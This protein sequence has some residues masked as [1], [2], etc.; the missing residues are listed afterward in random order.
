METNTLLSQTL[1]KMHNRKYSTIILFKEIGSFVTG[2]ATIYNIAGNFF[3]YNCSES[4]RK[5]DTNALKNDWGV[6]G[7]DIKDAVKKAKK[8]N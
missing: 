4:P 1:T 8:L 6:V 5:A 7:Y 2:I 3:D